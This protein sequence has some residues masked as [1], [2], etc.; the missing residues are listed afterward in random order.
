MVTLS[1]PQPSQ[2]TVAPIFRDEPGGTIGAED[3]CG[4]KVGPNLYLVQSRN[5]DY[6]RKLSRRSDTRLVAYS[7]RGGYLRTRAI[8]ASRPQL[9]RDFLKRYLKVTNEHFSALTTP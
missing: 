4:W 9:I 1:S 5:P 8:Y 6:A 2:T 3:L 7:V